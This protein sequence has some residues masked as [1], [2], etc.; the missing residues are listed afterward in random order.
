MAI[1]SSILAWRIPWMEETGGPQFMGSQ[2]V[3][4]DW[5]NLAHILR[6]GETEAPRGLCLTQVHGVSDSYL[7]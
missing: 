1:H 2:R 5:S 3:G 4:G 6:S 7:T